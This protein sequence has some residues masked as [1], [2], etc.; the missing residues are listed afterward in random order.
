MARLQT[1]ERIACANAHGGCATEERLVKEGLDGI[2]ERGIALYQETETFDR[3]AADDVAFVFAE[4]P[5]ERSGEPDLLRRAGGAG[6]DEAEVPA[7]ARLGDG[8]VGEDGGYL[9]GVGNEEGRIFFRDAAGN[10]GG[11][12]ALLWMVCRE[13]G[14]ELTR[15]AAAILTRKQLLRLR[16]SDRKTPA[17]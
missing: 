14:D 12:L 8:R 9:A 4:L 16:A 5:E 10:I 3:G 15:G 2:A 11:A 13:V 6:D 7:R 1:G 17:R